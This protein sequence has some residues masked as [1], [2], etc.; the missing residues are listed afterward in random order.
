MNLVLFVTFLVSTV[1]SSTYAENKNR[2]GRIVGG[3]VVVPHFHPYQACL[4]VL[5]E[6]T[7]VCGGSLISINRVLTAATCINGSTSTQVI[8]GAHDYTIFEPSQQRTT[9]LSTHYRIHPQFASVSTFNIAILMLRQQA[10]LT[11]QVG[12]ISLVPVNFPS[13]D[14]NI[15]TISGWGRTFDGGSAS[16]VLRSTLNFIISNAECSNFFTGI[17]DNVLC[18]STAGGR[19]PC[20]GEF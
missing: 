7:T 12:L 14:G 15:A 4:L 2:S 6:T 11:P 3:N 17:N 18:Q 10:V 1:T 13:V 8:L 20:G 16:R 19:G 9:V 5:R